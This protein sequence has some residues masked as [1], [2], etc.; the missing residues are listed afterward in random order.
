[1]RVQAVILI[2]VWLSPLAQAD[3]FQCAASDGS[4]TFQDQPCEEQAK[5]QRVIPE[6]KLKHW[7]NKEIGATS[8]TPPE[9]MPESMPEPMPEIAEQTRPPTAQARQPH[10]PQ[11]QTHTTSSATVNDVYVSLSY[12]RLQRVAAAAWADSAAAAS[13]QARQGCQQR[14]QQAVCQ[15]AGTRAYP[16]PVP[17]RLCLAVVAQ[18]SQRGKTFWVASALERAVAEEQAYAKAQCSAPCWSRLEYT[19][20]VEVEDGRASD[21]ATIIGYPSQQPKARAHAERHQA[22]RQNY[23]QRHQDRQQRYQQRHQQRRRD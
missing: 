1:M 20:C 4:L 9:S 21:N 10:Q 16:Q 11:T 3:V 5:L 23:Q 8:L 7:Q 2:S 13:E 18:N 12:A 14:A 22:R 15:S 19:Q 17:R 6:Q